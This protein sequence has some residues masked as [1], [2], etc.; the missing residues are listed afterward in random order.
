MASDAA[1][2]S[3]LDDA[4]AFTCRGDDSGLCCGTAVPTGTVLA[5]GTLR[6]VPNSGGR[7]RLED[8]SLCVE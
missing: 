2:S 6:P 3:G 5:R 1:L 4:P 7:Y 8:P